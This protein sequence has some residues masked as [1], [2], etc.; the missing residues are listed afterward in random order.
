MITL[1]SSTVLSPSW[2]GGGEAGAAGAGL[3]PP[4]RPGVG[5]ITV[6]SISLLQLID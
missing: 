1:V 2:D 3:A 5:F 6:S 4:L